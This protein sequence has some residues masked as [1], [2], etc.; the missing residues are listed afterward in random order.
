MTL[1]YHGTFALPLPIFSVQCHIRTL[2]VL[3]V[4]HARVTKTP[5]QRGVKRK[6][7]FLTNYRH[8]DILVLKAFLVEIGAI[9][10]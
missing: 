8:N 9:T 10:S 2:S 3:S 7:L 5:Q 6:G 1:R 4:R